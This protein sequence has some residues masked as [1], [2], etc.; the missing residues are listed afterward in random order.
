[1]AQ[2]QVLSNHLYVD[3]LV[4]L[5]RQVDETAAQQWLNKIRSDDSQLLKIMRAWS[6]SY[7][8]DS[9]ARR[10]LT[11]LLLAIIPLAELEEF[12]SA[13]NLDGTDDN[14]ASVVRLM[15]ELLPD[16]RNYAAELNEQERNRVEG[17]E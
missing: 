8:S 6:L 9:L 13:Y 4:K 15:R 1:M 16:I 17:A 5:W 14:D 3:Y 12:L 11:E 10:D 7:R 2:Q